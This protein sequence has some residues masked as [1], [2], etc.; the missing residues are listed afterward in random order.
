MDLSSQSLRQVEFREKMTRGYH[1]DDVDEFVERAA[2]AVETLQ[3]QLREANERADSAETKATENAQTDE[4]LRRTLV[5]AQRTADE[6]IRDAESHAASLVSDARA[7]ADAVMREAEQTARRNAHTA[8]E[9]LRRDVSMLETARTQL[10]QDVDALKR[11]LDTERGRIRASLTDALRTLDEGVGHRLPAPNPTPVEV[12]PALAD[13]GEDTM[14]HEIRLDD[15]S[16]AMPDAAESSS[17]SADESSDD[18]DDYFA[19]LRRAV[20]DDEP[21]G[22]REGP[23]LGGFDAEDEDLFG[24][25]NSDDTRGL[26]RLRRRR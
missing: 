15:S 25:A 10:Q 18:D 2:N 16:V 20:N 24:E 14:A 21:L 12:P 1:P 13:M 7:Q 8:Q 23:A 9:E 4:A 11:Y 19:E 5:I 17:S 6:A 3:Q 26:S 22:P